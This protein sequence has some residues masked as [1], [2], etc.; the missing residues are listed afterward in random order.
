MYIRYFVFSPRS[1]E[2]Q[3]LWNAGLATTA[4]MFNWQWICYS[5]SIIKNN[6]LRWKCIGVAA[7]AIAITSKFSNN[8]QTPTIHNICSSIIVSSCHL[9]WAI[10]FIC[11]LFLFVVIFSFFAGT[12]VVWGSVAGFAATYLPPAYHRSFHSLA[13]PILFVPV[14]QHAAFHGCVGYHFRFRPDEPSCKLLYD[15]TALLWRWENSSVKRHL[16]YDNE[17]DEKTKWL[18]C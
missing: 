18:Y 4:E 15:I 2:N 7:N 17:D 1:V 11:I 10:K 12:R 9:P 8:M 3:P 13:S 16:D 14:N 5:N 6:A